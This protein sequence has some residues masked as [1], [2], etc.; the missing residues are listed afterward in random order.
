M[1]VYDRFGGVIK[2]NGTM[3]GN[4]FNFHELDESNNPV[5]DINV[6]WD[7]TKLAGTFMNLKAKKQMTFAATPV[8]SKK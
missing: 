1:I 8:E 5:S 3:N 2:L 4:Q 6:N 7:G